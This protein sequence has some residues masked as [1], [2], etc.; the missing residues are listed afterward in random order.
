MNRFVWLLVLAIGLL[1]T[2]QEKKYP[3]Q[4]TAVSP[5]AAPIGA[6]ITLSGTQ[7]GDDPTVTM[8]GQT[9]PTKTRAD[10]AIT[11]TLPRLP[12]G[13][14]TIRVQN[15]DGTSAPLPFTV[16]QPLPFVSGFSPS[17]GQ[18]GS[19]VLISGTF[20]NDVTDVRFGNGTSS[21]AAFQTSGNSL[22]VVVPA[23]AVTGS[24]CLRN[25]GGQF[26][27][28]S[29]F[30]VTVP[31]PAPTITSV[32]PEKGCA[33]TEISIRGQNLQNIT[34]IRFGN[35]TVPIK[36]NTSNV[37]S[38]ITP[39][40]GSV[41]TVAIT[42]QTAGGL[43]NEG[44]FTGAPQATISQTPVPNGL[45]PGGPLTLRGT[46]FSSVTGIDF[47][48][49]NGEVTATVNA[50]S[51][52]SN[53]SG[54]CMIKVP[55]E[56]TATSI[57]VNNE[58]GHGKP[59]SISK[60]S[61]SDAIN[62]GNV[63][64]NV[65][66]ITTGVISDGCDPASFFY[67]SPNR[68]YEIGF[69]Y[70]SSRCNTKGYVTEQLEGRLFET[71]VAYRYTTGAAL[72][73]TDDLLKLERNSQNT[74][75]TGAVIIIAGNNGKPV[76]YVGNMTKAGDIYAYSVLNGALFKMCKKDLKYFSYPTPTICSDC[77]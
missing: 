48:N 39:E 54:S 72:I 35:Q 21:A 56:A 50:A 74:A 1:S 43:S 22:R 42:I 26:C 58:F 10:N 20:L 69:K 11:L 60:L 2:C 27:S 4:L 5:T 46:H 23:N 34:A 24:I 65:G 32:S 8:A 25:S 66:S 30:T 31:Q 13:A 45:I 44:R 64:T 3:P 68:G 29:V 52:L 61:G 77:K 47:M 62:T 15:A 59:Y 16:L 63:A 49:D 76:T 9:V 41:Q 53:E 38:V 36:S 14:T 71:Y 33:G 51:F 18:A 7:F 57:R 17:S 19:E 67:C 75:Y 37:V 70:F 12:V 6:D 40:F 28:L 55:V 73:A